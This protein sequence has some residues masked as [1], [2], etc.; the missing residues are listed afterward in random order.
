MKKFSLVNNETIRRHLA[1]TSP[2]KVVHSFSKSRR[3]DKPN[4][5]YILY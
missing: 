2:A 4:P 5:E 3:F 1:N